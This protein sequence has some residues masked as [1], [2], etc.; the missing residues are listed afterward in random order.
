MLKV[1]TYNIHKGF[2]RRNRE[3]VLH[4]IREQLES[5]DVDVVFLQEIQGRHFHHEKRIDGW[6]AVS[7]FEFLADGLWPHFAYGKN[8]IYQGGHHG[9]AILSKYPI[10]NWRNVNFSRF[11]RASRSLLHGI[12]NLPGRPRRLHLIC[13]HLE[14]LGFE[15]KRQVDIIRHHIG[16]YA[17]DDEPVIIAGDFNDW[18]GM[19]GRQFES[20]LAMREAHRS[21][22]GRYARTY[23][24]NRPMLQMDRVYFRQLGLID[25]HCLTTQ[26][27]G[28]LSDH[29]P[30]YAQFSLPDN[31]IARA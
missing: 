23:P 27:W 4:E 3:F 14:L 28:S 6:P 17:G 12:V 5:I 25:S 18:H 19:M 30:L 7:Q 10:E 13:T 1:L 11:R 22:H 21:M 29:L 24:A 31:G 15:R 8:A 9:N 16:D 2:D 26:P 20:L